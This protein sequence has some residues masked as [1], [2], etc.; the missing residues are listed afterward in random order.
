[1]YISLAN[2]RA[3]DF[4]SWAKTHRPDNDDDDNS[5]G[6][7]PVAGNATEDRLHRPWVIPGVGGAF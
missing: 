1:M 5:G 7:K 2:S 6:A 4:K 3:A